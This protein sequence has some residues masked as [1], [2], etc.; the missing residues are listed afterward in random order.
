MTRAIPMLIGGEWRLAAETRDVVDP[1]RREVVARMPLP[2][3][4]DLDAA[5]A[6]KPIMAYRP[7]YERAALL[8]RVSVLL[9]ERADGRARSIGADVPS[10]PTRPTRN[11]VGS[12]TV[13]ARACGDVS[14]VSPEHVGI[15]FRARK[16]VVIPPPTLTRLPQSFEI[17]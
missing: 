5:V 12:G 3:A 13:A 11:K 14:P 16:V 2:G 9:R 8:R 4:A 1:Y 6:A 10:R 7:G 17:A 15:R